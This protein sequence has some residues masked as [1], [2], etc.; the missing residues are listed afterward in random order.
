MLTVQN[1][2]WEFSACYLSQFLCR[3]PCLLPCI[4]LTL[5]QCGVSLHP[6]SSD[7]RLSPRWSQI[8][9]WKRQS[10]ERSGNTLIISPKPICSLLLRNRNIMDQ[11]SQKISF[12]AHDV[13]W[14][15]WHINLKI[16]WD[17][18]FCLINVS[19]CRSV[20]FC[21][22]IIIFY[23]M[24]TVYLCCKNVAVSFLLWLRLLIHDLFITQLCISVVSGSY[25]KGR[26]GSQE[27]KSGT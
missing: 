23:I 1:A 9:G 2:F 20:H 8:M 15:M 21:V 26:A 14:M 12:G 19:F 22:T 7:I 16:N 25:G 13:E 17:G 5:K 10:N 4:S 3:P 6:L 27:P 24:H 18:D 11:D